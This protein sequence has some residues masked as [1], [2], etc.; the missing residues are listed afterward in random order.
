[1][2]AAAGAGQEAVVNL[3]HQDAQA[4][5]VVGVAGEFGCN[6]VDFLA[7]AGSFP[8]AVGVL[9][10]GEIPG[11]NEIVGAVVTLTGILLVVL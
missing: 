7:A 2:G 4:S 8:G 9:F 11:V 1:V 3:Q 6:G 10:L 5:A